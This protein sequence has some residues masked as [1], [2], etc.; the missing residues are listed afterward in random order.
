MKNY[1]ILAILAN[2]T[3]NIIKYNTTLN[4]IS[5]I[6][7][8]VTN[9]AIVDTK[10]EYYSEK[11][12]NDI[13]NDDKINNYFLIENDNHFDFGKWIY[14]LKNIS[15]TN[16]DYILLFNDSI[17]LYESI[18]NYFIY[19][20]NLENPVNL[21]AYN[22]S[23][24]IQYHYQ[25]YFFS[26]SKKIVIKFIDF[27]ES[28]KHLIYNLE[29][30]I[31]NIELNMCNIDD[32]HDCLIKIAN[33]YNLSKN[34]YWENDILY[35]YLLTKNIFSV[36][37]L[38]KIYDIQ[39]EYKLTIYGRNIE[40]F[41]YDFYRTYYDDLSNLTD[42]KLL[43]HFIE[44]G[45]Y[46][47]RKFN[48]VFNVILPSYY[49]DKLEPAG[50]LYFFDVPLD[51][52]IF[53]Y[54]KNNDDIKNLSLLEAIFHYINFGIYEGRTYNKTNNKNFYFNNNYL[55]ILLRLNYIGETQLL[56]NLSN[57]NIKT[58]ILLTNDL[59]NC[60]YM[61][62]LYHY[63]KYNINNNIT[64]TKE[65]INKILINIDCNI[66]RK[67][68]PELSKYDDI[69]ILKHYIN[70][71]IDSFYKIPLDFDVNFYRKIY[72]DISTLNDE[73]LKIHYL[74]YGIKENR[75]YKIPDDFDYILYKDIYKDLNDLSE[76]NIKIHYLVNGI[77]ENRIY[78]LPNDFDPIT[79][80][81]IYKELNKL[82]DNELKKHYLY[83]GHIEK[84]I[85]KLPTDFNHEL[86]KKIYKDLA[87]YSKKELEEHYLYEGINENRI[88]K[89]PSDFNH[90]IYKKIYKDIINLSNE[91]LEKH[92]LFYGYNNNRIY[93]I[94]DDFLC[95]SYRKLNKDLINL[96]N[97]QL[98]E[99]YIVNGINE[100]RIYKK[101]ILKIFLMVLKIKYL[102]KYQMILIQIFI[103]IYMMI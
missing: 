17:I 29:S 38:K 86:Y 18:Q 36:I 7:N 92:Y 84:K 103:K 40:D 96:T 78:K 101:K 44:H 87:N 83:F 77:N 27:F 42:E 34:L 33:E 19:L 53:Y 28:K 24:Q 4:N 81:K 66:Y 100:N 12:K 54:L 45:Q 47:G 62:A 48:K 75:N 67:V 51:F 64:Y 22:D 30:L 58:Y 85:Y 74:L 68:Y 49:R 2:H 98:K 26:I 89:I 94:P 16:Y 6:K 79:Y 71:N 11:L 80:K 13:E 10:N 82:T 41:D 23:T 69:Q 59:N 102:I 46:E 9:I 39:K 25:S 72:S 76:E 63:L 31:T 88:Y 57:F 95:E 56:H 90:E 55:N 97:E 20:N 99:H 60:G 8:N 61:G 35:Q 91:E 5:F 73:D 3:I 1:K 50:L 70:N 37:K 65:S 93:K 14:A 52:D 32:N 21:Y 15:Y 43:N